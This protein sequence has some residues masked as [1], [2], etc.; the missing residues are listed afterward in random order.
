M[1]HSSTSLEGLKGS[2]GSLSHA[3]Q[4]IYEN[5]DELKQKFADGTGRRAASTIR[6][7]PHASH[8]ASTITP[9]NQDFPDGQSPLPAPM[10][11][12][13]SDLELELYSSW[14]YRRTTHRHS[15]SSLPSA[16]G[17]TAGWSFFSGISL[18][19]ISNISVISLPISYHEI[20]NAEHYM[21]TYNHHNHTDG[22]I[23]PRLAAGSSKSKDKRFVKKYSLPYLRTPIQLRDDRYSVSQR[24]QE[25]SN[26]IERDRTRERIVNV[27][28]LGKQILVRL[29]LRIT[30]HEDI[31]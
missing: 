16:F 29:I 12:A 5:S 15:T 19:E 1:I 25:I 4:S 3:V 6:S 21:S 7:L 17:S 2:I 18:A 8:E 9:L 10:P 31:G 14:V 30:F 23:S 22:Q 13:K 24:D 20:W 26:R 11:E 27:L 28:F